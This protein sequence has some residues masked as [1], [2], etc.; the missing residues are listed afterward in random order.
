MRIVVIAAAIN[1][2]KVMPAAA[3]PG[4][5][6]CPAPSVLMAPVIVPCRLSSVLTATGV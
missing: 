3:E 4:D 6:L 5:V 1:Y 2:S